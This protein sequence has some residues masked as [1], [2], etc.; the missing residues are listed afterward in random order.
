MT[1]KSL[2]DELVRVVVDSSVSSAWSTAVGEW[3]VVE[4]E[5]DPARGGVCVC[6]KTGLAKLF[7]IS[8]ERNGSF[9]H[10][11]GSVCVNQFGRTDLDRQVDLL[12]GLL[13]LRNAIHAR[14]YITLTSEYFSRAMLEYLY[15]EGAFTPDRWNNGDGEYDYEF[16]RKMFNK[17]DKDAISSAQVRKINALL[18]NKVFPFVLADERLR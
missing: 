10:P 15:S 12:T 17:R 16:L 4:L 14:Q 2:F 6:G 8:N 3:T 7:T 13:A 1:T 9:L 11:I 18:R 5:D